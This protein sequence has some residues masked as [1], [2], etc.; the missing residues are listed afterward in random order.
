MMCWL[1]GHKF[2]VIARG[3]VLPTIHVMGVDHA[4]TITLYAC[5]RCGELANDQQLINLA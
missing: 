3:L 1:V 4:D 2:G 5:D